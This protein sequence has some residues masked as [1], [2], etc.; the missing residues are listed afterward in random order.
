M[1]G[2]YDNANAVEHCST[3]CSARATLGAYHLNPE[4]LGFLPTHGKRNDVP[5]GDDDLPETLHEAFPGIRQLRGAGQ[6]G[7][8]IYGTMESGSL[9]SPTYVE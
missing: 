1:E 6:D 2:N 8:T 9:S 3:A 5:L 4:L 7:A